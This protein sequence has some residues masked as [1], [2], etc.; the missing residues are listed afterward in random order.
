MTD[1]EYMEMAI[2]LAKKGMGWTN[3]NPMVG[4]VVVKDGRIIGTGYHQKFGGPHAERNA[5]AACRESAAGAALYVTLEPCCHTGKTPPCTE[6]ILEAGIAKV[7]VG[8]KDPNP[9]V[10]GKGI[11][12]LKQA[13]VEV[14]EDFLKEECDALNPVFFHW[15]QTGL[16]Y[17]VCKYAMSADGKIAAWTGESQW[18]SNEASR[19]HVHQIR[20]RY[21]AILAGIQTVLQDDPLLTC[22]HDGLPS[23]VRVIC[24]SHLRIPEDSQL[25]NSAREFDL[26]VAC[27]Q[28]DPAKKRRLEQKGVQVWNLPKKDHRVDLKELMIRLGASGIDSVLAEGGAEIHASLLQTGLVQKCLVYI[29]GKILGGRQAKSPVGGKGACCPD[30]G[31]QLKMPKVHR[32]ENDIL[33][34][35]ELEAWRKETCLQG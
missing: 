21:R 11:R 33:L 7:F 13:G 14:I 35:Y 3:P 8:S 32:F 28:A 29:G 12:Q 10:C 16:P 34:E 15:I 25:V 20:G 31:V 2:E 6:A 22:R 4:A 27:I 19:G 30:L 26:I 9:N 1:Q 24:D 23:P 5:I 18:I 17:L